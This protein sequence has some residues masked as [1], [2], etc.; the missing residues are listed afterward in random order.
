[1]RCPQC[2][3]K[4]LQKSGDDTKL[5]TQGQILFTKEGQCLAKCYWCKTEVRLPVALQSER[6]LLRKP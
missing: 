4:L 5:R 3:N 2:S 1:M 6:F